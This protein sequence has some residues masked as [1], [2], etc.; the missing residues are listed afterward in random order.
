MLCGGAT[1]TR[2]R[3]LQLSIG[4]RTDHCMCTYIRYSRRPLSLV[5]LYGNLGGGLS[6]SK[7][8]SPT[9]CAGIAIESCGHVCITRK[10]RILGVLHSGIGDCENTVQAFVAPARFPEL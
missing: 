5:C 7:Q 9:P 8:K 4:G 2:R 3:R 6:W 10:G 1:M